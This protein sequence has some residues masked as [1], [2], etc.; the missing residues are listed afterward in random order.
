MA[1]RKRPDIDEC[2]EPSISAN[3]AFDATTLSLDTPLR[4][5]SL[6]QATNRTQVNEMY[7]PMDVAG[8]SD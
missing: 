3:P 7:A 4:K 1:H 2:D 5:A 6:I 8:D